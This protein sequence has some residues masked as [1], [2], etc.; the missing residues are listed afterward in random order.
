MMDYLH[1]GPGPLEGR[2]YKCPFCGREHVDYGDKPPCLP[3]SA[4]E[5]AAEA[6]RQRQ[7]AEFEAELRARLRARHDENHEEKLRRGDKN[8]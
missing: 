6:E 7:A 3:R 1:Y 4:A 8:H 2:A 5:R